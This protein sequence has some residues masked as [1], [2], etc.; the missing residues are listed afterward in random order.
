MDVVRD[1]PAVEGAALDLLAA[2]PKC[3]CGRPARHV[4]G[5]TR[6][7]YRYECPAGC[8]RFDVEGAARFA[9]LVALFRPSSPNGA[10]AWRVVQDPGGGVV[11]AA[12]DGATLARMD[13]PAAARCSPDQL[14]DA[15]L[16]VALDAASAVLRCE[17]VDA[18]MTPRAR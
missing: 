2:T 1:R 8:G 10:G 15:A 13:A 16:G 5:D 7:R 14:E 18:A 11:V 6:G 12:D 9:H 17:R 4:G 3:A